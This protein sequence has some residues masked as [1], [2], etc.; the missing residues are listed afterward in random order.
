[1]AERY[2]KLAERFERHMVPLR[3][4]VAVIEEEVRQA[5]ENLDVDLPELPE[6][7]LDEDEERE[8]LFDSKREFVEQT[9]HFRKAQG[10]E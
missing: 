10:K 5:V 4:E 7:E 9:D 8:W 1:V 3:D 2:R 6:G